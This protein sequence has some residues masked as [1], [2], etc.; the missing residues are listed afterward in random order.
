MKQQIY[1]IDL[2]CIPEKI[3]KFLNKLQDI[4]GTFNSV[5]NVYY[6]ENKDNGKYKI[7]LIIRKSEF[8]I[9]D[10]KIIKKS[11]SQ[12]DTDFHICNSEKRNNNYYIT[13]IVYS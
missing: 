10:K 9:L 3:R 1:K 8:D 5:Y 2:D 4:F 7:E 11:L 13:F 6:L 12:I